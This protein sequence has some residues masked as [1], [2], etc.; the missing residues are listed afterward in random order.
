[1]NALHSFRKAL[2]FFHG[3]RFLRLSLISISA[4]RAR[5]SLTVIHGHVQ[6]LDELIGLLESLPEFRDLLLAL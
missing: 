5:R 2:L 3:H 1:M 4:V 6:L